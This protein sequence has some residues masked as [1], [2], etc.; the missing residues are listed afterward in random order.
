MTLTHFKFFIRW[1]FSCYPPTFL[2]SYPELRVYSQGQHRQTTTDGQSSFVLCTQSSIL[3]ESSVVITLTWHVVALIRLLQA[4][5]PNP[6]RPREYSQ[7]LSL[8]NSWLS[9]LNYLSL[10]ANMQRWV[11]T[12]ILCKNI[13]CRLVLQG[14]GLH[15]SPWLMKRRNLVFVSRPFLDLSLSRKQWKGSSQSKFWSSL[16]RLFDFLCSFF[17]LFFAVF[18]LDITIF[19]NK[20][21]LRLWLWRIWHKIFLGSWKVNPRDT[22]TAYPR[23]KLAR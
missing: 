12:F 13:F 5:Y 22:C 9:W 19:F 14:V 1:S 6:L 21:L 23:V 3:H 2:Y 17:L 7:P 4:S 18:S 20:Y 15:I 16:F 10:P 11:A 8:V